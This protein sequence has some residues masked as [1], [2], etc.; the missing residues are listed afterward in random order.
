MQ[1]L[2][3]VDYYLSLYV[4]NREYF[5]IF[6]RL[7]TGNNNKKILEK[8]VE[9]TKYISP[10]YTYDKTYVLDYLHKKWYNNIN[11]RYTLK[12]LNK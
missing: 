5:S 6:L 9:N 7:K 11:K 4:L 3:E 8:R 12:M 2:K 10:N 1:S